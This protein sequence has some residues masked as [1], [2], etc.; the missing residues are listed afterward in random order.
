[1]ADSNTTANAT[2][3]N[4]TQA[5]NTA[6]P[7][8]NAAEGSTNLTLAHLNLLSSA[9]LVAQRRGT[10]SLEESAV[11][12]EPVKLVSELVKKSNEQSQNAATPEQET[13]D[14]NTDN[15]DTPSNDDPKLVV[16]QNN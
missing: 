16:N 6:A 8:G 4:A 12:V 15:S 7:Q 5:A 10:F 11:L 2:Q 1:M 14:N 3:A 13:A 9:V